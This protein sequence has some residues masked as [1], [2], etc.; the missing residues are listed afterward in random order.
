MIHDVCLVVWMGASHFFCLFGWT[1][2]VW[3]ERN[4]CLVDWIMM[5]ILIMICGTH[6]SF[7]Y[8]IVIM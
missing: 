3:D 1:R 7:I 6:L 5:T 2:L 8:F 4:F